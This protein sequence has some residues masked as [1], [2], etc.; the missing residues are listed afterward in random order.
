MGPACA[1]LQ[2][3]Q[4]YEKQPS[5]ATLPGKDDLAREIFLSWYGWYC[6]K[7]ESIV[8]GPAGT[9]DKSIVTPLLVRT[10][11]KCPHCGPARSPRT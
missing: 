1:I 2:T 7:L 6:E 9:L 4:E 5:I 10:G 3:R 8:S 11:T